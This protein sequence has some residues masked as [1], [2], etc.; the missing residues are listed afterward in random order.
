MALEIPTIGSPNSTQDPKIKASLETLSGLLGASNKIGAAGLET[1]VLGSYRLVQN[2][3]TSLY[4]AVAAG[5][6]QFGTAAISTTEKGV[7]SGSST[8]EF[9]T[10]FFYFAAADYT[11]T[12][13]TQKLRVRSQIAVNA[14]KPTLKFTVGLYPI[15]VAG[16]VNA[17]SI[18]LGTV[19]SGSTIEF[20]EPAASTIGQGNS[21][22]FTV[23]SDGAYAFGVVTSGAL[24][25]NSA[26]NV[27]AQLQSRLV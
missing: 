27:S 10:H 22:D 5:T 21:G 17:L 3:R 15:T 2:A 20:N 8:R 4:E 18:T 12:G 14:T 6:Y 23:P 9:L 7:V 24:T 19:V 26:V 16:G 13:R 1:D 11:T 25:A